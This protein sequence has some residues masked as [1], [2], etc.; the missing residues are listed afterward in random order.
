VLETLLL[1]NDE[2][3]RCGL[4]LTDDSVVEL[5]NLANDPVLGYIMDP[6][7]VL[8]YLTEGRIKGTWHTHPNGSATLSGEDLKGFAGWPQFLH[9]VI[10]RKGEGVEVRCYR[11]IGRA[12]VE[13][14]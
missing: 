3:E 7:Q 6:L 14:E 1:P 12:V 4:L 9:Y 8:P 5:E 11:V 2:K 10:G 13:C